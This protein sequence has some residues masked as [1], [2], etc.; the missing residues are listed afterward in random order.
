MSGT[1]LVADSES[2]LRAITPILDP[3]RHK[4]QAG[5]IAVIGGCRVYTVAPYFAAI[6]ALKIAADLSHL[7]CTKDAAPVLKGYSPELIVHPILEESYSISG[8]GDEERK[9]ISSK[10]LAEVDKWIERFDCLVVGPGLGRDPYFLEGVSEIMKHAR[11]SNFQI[12][13]DGVNKKD[14]YGPVKSVS[15]YGSPRRCGGQGDILSGSAMNPTVLGCI[16]AS[17]LLRKAAS[18]AFENKKRSTLTSN[19]IECLGRSLEDI[20]LAGYYRRS[21]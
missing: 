17:A 10:I 1:A 8:L 21:N 4:G 6:S 12:V 18:H 9:R 20:S 11:R 13:I 5:K 15:I 16:A 19:I 2:I 7:F 14:E 3:N